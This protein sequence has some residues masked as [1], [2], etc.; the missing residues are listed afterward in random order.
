MLFFISAVLTHGH[1]GQLPVGPTSI[2]S[3]ANLCML[4]T[5]CFLMLIYTDF[6][7]ST[8]A[9]HLCVILSTI[10]IFIHV[11]GCGGRGPSALLFPGT[12]NAAN[13]ALF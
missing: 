1:A 13:T 9:I 3:H 7:G 5:S 8:N 10:Y 6:V 2:G 12:Y 4:C 11:S